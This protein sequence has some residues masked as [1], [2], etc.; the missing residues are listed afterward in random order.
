MK[1]PRSADAGD[2][3]RHAPALAKGGAG[4]AASIRGSAAE[5]KAKVFA[6]VS[7]NEEPPRVPFASLIHHRRIWRGL[8]FS[9]NAFPI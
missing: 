2:P 7:R 8:L 4:R 1:A 5:E 3:R 9:T 6:G